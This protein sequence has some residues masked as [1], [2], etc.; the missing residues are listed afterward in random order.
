MILQAIVIPQGDVPRNH[1]ARSQVGPGLLEKGT[2]RKPHEH[3]IQI[4]HRGSTDG[5][6]R[7]C[8]DNPERGPQWP[9]RSSDRI[10]RRRDSGAAIAGSP[11]NSGYYGYYGDP[12]YAYGYAPGYAYDSY[13]YEPAPVYGY[14]YTYAPAYSRYGYDNYWQDP[15]R[16][17]NFSI[18][19]QR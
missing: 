1:A 3:D 2:E 4:R 11:Y 14:G 9:K 19:S 13:A 17:N 8:G 15:H 12:G 5:C 10:R 7:A 16:T 6:T 18:S